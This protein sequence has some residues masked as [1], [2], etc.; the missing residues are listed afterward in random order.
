MKTTNKQFISYGNIGLVQLRAEPES[1]FSFRPGGPELRSGGLKIIEAA[2]EGVV[3]KLIA[4][5]NTE[6]HLL[7]I[8]GD[9]LAGA[10]QNRI[11]NRSILL[12]PGSKTVIDVSCIE[13][14]RWRY[15]SDD[16]KNP[17]S[18]A[19]HDLRS[20]KAAS[21]SYS[22]G[23]EEGSPMETQQR[24]WVHIHNEMKLMNIADSTENYIELTRYSK[25]SKTNEIPFPEFRQEPGC[26]GL[27]V[28]SE[29]KV[30]CIDI[31]GTEE[32]YGYYFPLLRDAA[33]SKALNTDRD[34]IVD[35]QEAFFRAVDALDAVGDAGRRVDEKYIGSGMMKIA[36]PDGLIGFE[37]TMDGQP[38]HMAVF[39]R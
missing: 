34:D 11:L 31:F 26:N 13:R 15:V 9:M 19:D 33:F 27:A 32:V 25:A 22:F 4:E 28:I 23:Q 24:V 6:H 3:G 18:T 7:L 37:L 36:E 38:V 17:D 29:G 14:L 8:D 39:G 5:N 1:T 30:R 2:K 20:A 21:A 16:F 35:I 10:K 12:A